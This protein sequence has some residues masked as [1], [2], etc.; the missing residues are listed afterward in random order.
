MSR[1]A[2]DDVSDATL[3]VAI[4]RWQQ[5]ALAEAFRRHSGAVLALARRLL[6]QGPQAEEVVQEVF[7]RLWNNPE[8][9]DAERGS[10]RSFLLAQ[11]HSRSVDM[12]RAD[13][14]RRRREDQDASRDA[15]SKYDLEHEVVDVIVAEQ[16]RD[17]VAT[18]APQERQA[19]ELA[20]FGGHTYREVAAMLGE[21]E[22]TIKSRIRTGMGRLRQGLA[23]AGIG[24]A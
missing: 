9:F 6:N 11:C 13:T 4:G 17:A 22:G 23:D 7:L 5:E 19:V 16:V 10:L 24:P 20:Y 15:V 12:L 21:P 2:L 1:G 8:R 18:L 14:S 3:V